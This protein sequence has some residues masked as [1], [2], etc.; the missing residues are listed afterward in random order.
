MNIGFDC[1][2]L[3]AQA[4]NVHVLEI[5]TLHSEASLKQVLPYYRSDLEMEKLVLL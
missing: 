3:E 5:A 1:R 4:F 2:S